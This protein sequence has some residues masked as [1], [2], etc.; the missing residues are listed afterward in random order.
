MAYQL[1][2]FVLFCFFFKVAN[3]TQLFACFHAFWFLHDLRDLPSKSFLF[4]CYE[5][6]DGKI[7]ET[8]ATQWL[9]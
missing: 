2:Y 8:L 4:H 5:T 7:N 6:Q 1:L 9:K 3:A